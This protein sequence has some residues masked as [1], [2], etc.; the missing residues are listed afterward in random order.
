MSIE[1]VDGADVDAQHLLEPGRRQLFDFRRN[2]Q[3]RRV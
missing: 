2:A 1:D 3:Q